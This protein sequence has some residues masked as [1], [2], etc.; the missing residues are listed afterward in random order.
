MGRSDQLNGRYQELNGKMGGLFSKQKALSLLITIGICISQSCLVGTALARSVGNAE[1]VL[2]LVPAPAPALQSVAGRIAGTVRDQSGGVIAGAMVTVTNTAQGTQNKTIT[3]ARG[4]YTFPSLPVGRYDLKIEAADFKPESRTN[5]VVDI[6]SALQIDIVLTLAQVSQEVTITENSATAPVTVETVSTQ[7]GEVVTAAQITEVALNGRSYTDLL[8]LQPGIVPVTTQTPDSIIMSGVTTAIAPS[9]VLN[10]GNQSISGQREDANG[11]IVNGGDVKELMNGGTLVVPNLDSIAEFRVLTNNFD[12]Q[13][14]NYS[15][16]VITVVTKSGTNALHGSG[17]EFLRNT[18][19]DARNFF[20]PERS[21]FRQNQFGGT[22]GG[23]VKKNQ[24]FFFADYQGTRQSQGVDTGLIPV[25][26]LADRT[27]NLINQADAITATIAPDGSCKVHCVSGPYL[28]SLLSKNLGYTVNAGDA[29]YTPGCVRPQCVFPNAVIPQSA[30]SAPTTHLLQYIPR[31]NLGDATFTTGSQGKILRDDKGSFRLET[32][33]QRFGTLSGYYYVD[34][35]NLNNPYPVGQ[36]GANVPGFNAFNI[37]RGQLATISHT[38]AFG[39]SMVNELRVSLMRNVNTIGQPQG[40][41][42]PSLASQGFVTGVGTPGIVPLA[43]NIEGVENVV[44]NAFSIGVPITNLAQANNTFSLMD[45]FSLVKGAHTWKSGFQ[46]SYEQVNVKPDAT[47]NGTFL[48]TGS[49]T[50][51]DFADFLLG[52]ASGYNQADSEAYYPRHK[53]VAAYLQDSWRVKPNVT[54][55]YGVRWDLMQYWSEKYNQVPTVIPGEQS[56]VYPTAPASLVYA[57]DPGVPRTLVPQRNKFAPRV[58]IAYSPSKENGLIGKLIGKPGKT[59][60]RAGFGLFYSV[61]Q[62]NTI[63]IDEPQP[64]YGLSYTSPGEPLFAT[65]FI[66]APDGRAHVN[67][68]PLNFP[69]LNATARHPNP[70]IDFSPFLPQAGMDAPPPSNTY[71][72]NENYFLS[73]EREVAPNTVLS[74]GYVGSQAH[75]LLVIHSANPGNPSLCLAL[76]N[77]NAVAPGS[78][79]CGPFGEDNTY[80]TS[81]GQVIQGTRVGLGPSFSNDMFISSMGNSTS[82]ALETSL[83]HTGEKLDVMVAY[84]F[85]KSLDQSS[86]LSDPVDPY[87]FRRTKALSAWDLTHNLVTTYR[88]ALPFDRFFGRVRG[89]ADGW[90]LS[91]IVR[92]STGLPV[93][94]HSDGDNSLLGSVPNGVNNHSIDL[95]DYNGAPLRI[96]GNPR[97]GLTYFDTSAFSINALGTPGTASRRFFHGPGATNFDLALIK[98]INLPGERSAQFR[99][100]A[101]NAFN[102][103]QFFGP[104][105]VDGGITTR[106]FGHVVNAAPPR[107]VQL[108]V[109]V[110]F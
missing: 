66:T 93:T 62:G 87:N 37:G 105:A 95:P 72:Y 109:K 20:S 53:Y 38:K 94:L 32:N 104:S 34:D 74:V 7:V 19:L 58:G 57:T 9:G 40:G 8:A 2:L 51:S 25:P 107:L 101:F 5:L 1:T 44:F 22:L 108:A 98:S 90:T 91:G 102:H 92:A 64:P 10:A 71:P 106:L 63:G 88:Y 65:P 78:A 15:G 36:G 14:G 85:S 11:F 82:N 96:N 6:N 89:L 68:F 80:T 47:Y 4:L 70:N 49:E 48:F 73:I 99:L 43:P 84:T 59:S 77:P 42:G 16:G 24:L 79:T 75:H 13:Y 55:N 28:A 56:Q 83:R 76:S 41:V 67:P 97:N 54:F 39:T 69:P 33:S 86:A 100:E 50:G 35:Y 60:V 17:F 46:L 12:A 23:P 81:Q 30:W 27:G 110:N 21:F 103:A 3:D 26:A 45:D 29:Y 18:A 31:P 61:I 52:V